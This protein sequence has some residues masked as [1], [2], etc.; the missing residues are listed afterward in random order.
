[1]EITGQNFLSQ[2]GNSVRVRSCGI[3]IVNDSILLAGHNLP[4]HEGLFWVPP[5]GGVTFGETLEEGLKREFYEET[6][7]QVGVG[8][9]LFVNE[10][11][12]PPLHAIEFFFLIES[13]EGRLVSGYDPEH[14]VL[15][16]ILHEVKFMTM[17]EIQALPQHS[18]HSMF[19]GIENLTEV[20]AIRGVLRK[21]H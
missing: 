15:E 10:F 19:E 12:K 5:G 7:L 9:L 6:G 4:G 3:C 11:I 17:K 18:V 20:T 1:L 13:M 8:E 2:Y 14:S 21:Q 16:Q